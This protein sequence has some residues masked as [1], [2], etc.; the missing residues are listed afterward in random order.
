MSASRPNISVVI[1]VYNEASNIDLLY[2][3]LKAALSSLGPAE[4]LFINDGSSDTT[5]AK[6]KALREKDPEVKYLSFSRNFGHQIAVTAGLDA[7][8]GEAVVIIDADLQD[9]PEIIPSLY[10][11]FREGYEVVYAVRSRRQGEGFFKKATAKVFYRLLRYLTG[12]SI[13][14]DV[15]DF[16]LMS[17][18]AVIVFN[19]LRERHRYVRGMVSWLGFR[20][21]GVEY[22]RDPRHSG[23][24]KYSLGKM[25]KLALDGIT[26]FSNVP[27]QIAGHMGFWISGISLLYILYILGMKIF[28]DKPIIGWASTMTAIFFFGGV[29]LITLGVVGE[30]IGRISDEVK[31]RP[32]Y[33]VD[34]QEGLEP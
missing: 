29:Q 28:T 7:S 22:V 1:P 4:Y 18:K 33:I 6:V 13:P 12:F 30:Y 32:I 11:K 27:L 25:F 26:S 10:Q 3:R 34:E 24:T 16:R 17:R 9:P 8:S 20:Q 2:Q 21:I 23:E 5:L 19:K 15:G 14:V 31:Q